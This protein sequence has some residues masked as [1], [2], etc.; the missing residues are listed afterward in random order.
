MTYSY[1]AE[2]LPAPGAWVERAA[3]A[4]LGPRDDIWFSE[5]PG[6]GGLVAKKQ[7]EAICRRCDALT[8]CAAYIAA[9]PQAGTWAATTEHDRKTSRRAAS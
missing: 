4:E 6:G 9:N 8:E 3:C 7:A 5:V 2:H 1:R